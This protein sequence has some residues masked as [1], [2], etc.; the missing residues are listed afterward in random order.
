MSAGRV[1]LGLRQPGDGIRALV[2][3]H[4]L[5]KVLLVPA[6]HREI[7]VRHRQFPPPHHADE[8]S[9]AVLRMPSP[10]KEFQRR[11]RVS[12]ADVFDDLEQFV[13]V[14]ALAAGE[15]DEFLCLLDDGAPFERARNCDATPASELEQSLVA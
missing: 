15:G 10:L 1:V 14:V 13:E 11:T 4:Q 8:V 3:L 6:E 2:S 5:E 12:S 7:R 9:N